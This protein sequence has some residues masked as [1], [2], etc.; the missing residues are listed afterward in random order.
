[1]G[2]D[3]DNNSLNLNGWRGYVHYDG[4]LHL[5][6]AFDSAGEATMT[7]FN[8]S[9]I[10]GQGAP[11]SK[12]FGGTT[13]MYTAWELL[14]TRNLTDA[15]RTS[16]FRSTRRYISFTDLE[17]TPQPVHAADWHGTTDL[18]ELDARRGSETLIRE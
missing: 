9:T 8:G 1:M 5:I 17:V 11:V 12:A 6:H 14:Q 10:V 18:R 15:I 13:Y 4:G 3:K 2:L 7:N 16:L